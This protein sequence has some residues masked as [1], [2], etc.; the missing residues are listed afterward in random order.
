MA[1]SMGPMLQ[2]ESFHLGSGRKLL[3]DIGQMA[4]RGEGRI[5]FTGS[6]AGFLPGTFQAVYNGTKAFVDSFAIALRHE[7]ADSGVSTLRST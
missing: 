7:L 2:E 3:K 6:I 1:R 5:L 4:A